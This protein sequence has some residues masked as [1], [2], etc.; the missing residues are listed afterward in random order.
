MRQMIEFPKM[1]INLDINRIA[2]SMG[3]ID[4]YWYGVIIALG[5]L[6][7]TIYACK[8]SKDFSLKEND[9]LD[10]LLVVAPI[11]I[12][13]ARIYYVAFTWDNYKNDLSSIFKIWE[14][15]IAIY[16]AIIG[17]IIAIIIYAK[18]KK[19]NV[20]DLLD[21]GAISVLIGQFIG[22]WG[23][24]VNG[25]AFGSQTDMPWG[26]VIG[27]SSVAVHPTFLY[28]SLWNAAGFV[29]LHFYSKHRKFKGEM[30][31]LYFLWYGIGRSMIEGLRT[32]S[33]YIPG[34]SIRVSQ[35]FAIITAIVSI[36]IL[37][38][39]YKKHIKKEV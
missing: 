18:F 30:T 35:V 39:G 21:L 3:N 24:F 20:L 7:A 34:T 23:N 36:V 4:I 22:R 38:L 32:D 2:F 37:I 13:C 1:G 15:G 14:G 33:L 27:T 26:M 8:R 19:L 6:L 31:A 12:I 29:L 5:F 11:A 17:G 10:G 28:E 25:E 16:G 9:I